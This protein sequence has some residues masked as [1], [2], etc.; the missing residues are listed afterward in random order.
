MVVGLLYG[1]QL[2]GRFGQLGVA[3][4]E[5]AVRAEAGEE[6]GSVTGFVGQQVHLETQGVALLERRVDMENVGESQ[7]SDNQAR[8]VR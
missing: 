2:S 7:G 5:V 1:D 8:G 6:L 3:A 4:A